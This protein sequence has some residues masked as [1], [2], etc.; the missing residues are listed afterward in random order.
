VR[1]ADPENCLIECFLNSENRDDSHN[2]KTF[3][4]KK[5]QGNS[6]N[7]PQEL[8]PKYRPTIVETL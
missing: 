5:T 4:R 3:F 7:L 6:Q 1:F 8:E 2:E